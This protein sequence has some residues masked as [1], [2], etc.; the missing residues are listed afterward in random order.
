[1]IKSEPVIH[2]ATVL[3]QAAEG[4]E[5]KSTMAIRLK[6]E[7]TKNDELRRQLKENEENSARLQ[8][9]FQHREQEII[10]KM[11]AQ[12]QKAR[13]E[14]DNLMIEL[15]KRSQMIEDL[16]KNDKKV[17]K[18]DAARERQWEEDLTRTRFTALKER[19]DSLKKAETERSK[20]VD[21]LQAAIA[22]KNAEINRLRHLL[23][24]PAV[25]SHQA[26]TGNSVSS[27]LVWRVRRGAISEFL[28]DDSTLLDDEDVWDM[29]RYFLYVLIGVIVV[30]L[31]V[32]G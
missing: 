10:D 14:G 26:N 5:N 28:L 21:S 13:E 30:S 3:L 18:Q 7:Q 22:E 8:K 23:K 19:Y 4:A 25:E 29:M 31:I 17:K 27:G 15:Q 9:R 12:V 1:M 6:Q 20:S 32:H 16:R 11:E 2:S 24:M